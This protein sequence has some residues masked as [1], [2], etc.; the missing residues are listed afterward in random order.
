MPRIRHGIRKILARHRVGRLRHRRL[1]QS[2]APALRRVIGP[3]E[4]HDAEQLIAEPRKRPP[5]QMRRIFHSPLPPNPPMPFQRKS[6]P[7]RGAT[8][9]QQPEPHRRRRFKKTVERKNEQVGNRDPEQRGEQT[10]R[11]FDDP[12]ATPEIGEFRFQ[13]RRQIGVYKT[14]SVG[15]GQS[16]QRDGRCGP[17]AT[18]RP[19][20]SG[21]ASAEK[22]CTKT[23]W[24]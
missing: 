15:L 2:L 10:F 1:H 18:L 23:I 11:E 22:T 12:H 8:C 16:W 19:K 3:R 17:A 4:F 24:P 21:K 6:Q 13:N 7:E 5:Q 14:R 9:D 20:K